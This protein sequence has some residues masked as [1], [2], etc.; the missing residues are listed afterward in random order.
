MK[1]KNFMAGVLT[2]ML[3]LSFMVKPEQINSFVPELHGK[4]VDIYFNDVLMTDWGDAI[5][6][7]DQNGRTMIPLRFY[8]EKIGCSIEWS[9]KDKKIT[10][11]YVQKDYYGNDVSKKVITLWVNNR[12]TYVYDSVTNETKTIWLD[13]VPWQEPKYPW[14]TFV[15]LRFV[16]EC[17]GDI[18]NWYPKGSQTLLPGVI[19]N[20]DTVFLAHL[21]P[22][23]P[24]DD[25]QIVSG[26][27]IGKYH[28][29]W[30]IEQFIKS[31]GKIKDVVLN[32][33]PNISNQYTIF[34]SSGLAIEWKL[35]TGILQIS[36][37]LAYENKC[38]ILSPNG[39]KYMKY[40]ADRKFYPLEQI[41]NDFNS[42]PHKFRVYKEIRG[43]TDVLAREYIFDNGIELVV[44]EDWFL[45]PSF[46]GYWIEW[47]IFNKPGW[48]TYKIATGQDLP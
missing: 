26:E 48:Y 44:V 34:F 6:F 8:S 20:K 29:D 38:W 33:N 27:R 2:L 37:S 4:A 32:E 1:R 23:I 12:K 11:T 47:L 7:I 39:N 3:L 45:P 10:I 42:W 9:Q 21:S 30:T 25:Y 31:E 40:V 5:P 16:S 46:R 18:V 14:R 43:G 28:L 22:E 13:T 19:A 24:E 15:P 41:E 35:N 36:P 17:L